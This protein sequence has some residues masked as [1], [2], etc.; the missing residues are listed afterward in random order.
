MHLHGT[1][2]S[3]SPKFKMRPYKDDLFERNYQNNQLLQRNLRKF[4]KELNVLSNFVMT[5]LKLGK[6]NMPI[7]CAKDGAFH[8]W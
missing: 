8:F 7:P 6:Q 4:S 3:F 5:T 2:Y 1:G